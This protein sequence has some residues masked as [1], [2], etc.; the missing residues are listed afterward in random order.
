[1][2]DF[3]AIREFYREMLPLIE[4]SP[5]NDWAADP[6]AW[7]ELIDMTP[8]EAWL[9]TDIRQADVILYPQFPVDR[10]FVD[11]ANPRAKVAIE[12]DGRAYHLDKAK[13]AARDAVLESLGWS[14]Y[15][16]TG[17]DCA[18]EFNEETRTPS[19][20]RKF[21][22]DIAQWHG[23]KRVPSKES[24]PNRWFERLVHPNPGLIRQAIQRLKEQ[25]AE[26]IGGNDVMK[27]R[28]CQ[29]MRRTM[30]SHLHGAAA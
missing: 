16:I 6:Y 29:Q 19:P 11:F 10:F 17:S 30:E 13:D 26:A 24:A 9:W 25:E 21:I 4:S 12:C 1:M 27:L 7:S 18:K 5:K 23:I 8:I 20:A 2:N 22:D 28:E 15:R 14:V 3:R